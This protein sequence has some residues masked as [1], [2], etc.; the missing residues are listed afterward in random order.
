MQAEIGGGGKAF[1]LHRRGNGLGGNMFDITAP[2]VQRFDL[3]RINV[4]TQDRDS[5]ARELKRQGKPDI[6]QPDDC[7]FHGCIF[8]FI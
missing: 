3:G 4:Q 8:S 6:T 5:R 1:G 7:Y 2:A